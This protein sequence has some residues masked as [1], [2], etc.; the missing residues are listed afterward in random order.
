MLNRVIEHKRKKI[1]SRASEVEKLGHHFSNSS[2]LGISP[3]IHS[4][5]NFFLIGY[6]FANV[7]NKS[8]I[9]MKSQMAVVWSSAFPQIFQFHCSISLFSMPA[10]LEYIAM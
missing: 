2:T 1:I 5:L 6:T 3:K 10:S 9:Q 8:V 4:R 7:H